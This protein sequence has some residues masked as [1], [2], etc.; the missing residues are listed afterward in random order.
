MPKVAYSEEERQQIRDDLI[1]TALEL[2]VEQGIQHTTVEQIYKKVGISRTFF[3]SFFST[4][5]DLVI[6]ALY[7]QQPKIIAYVNQLISDPNLTWHDAVRKFIYSCCN[8]AKSGFAVMSLDEQ[9]MLFQR[10]SEENY[11]IF[12]KK[13]LALFGKILECFGIQPSQ[14]RVNLFINLCLTIIL[15]YR[16]VPERLPFFVAEAAEETTRFQIDAVINHLE[17]LKVS[18]P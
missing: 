15:I 4:K 6:E 7:C 11:D 1:C 18:M 5:E 10:L 9:R 13:Q 12:R 3:Y 14:E 2:M 8:G 16:S 17:K